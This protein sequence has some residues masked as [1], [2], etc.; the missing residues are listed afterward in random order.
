MES[1]YRV[2]STFKGSTHYWGSDG[3][4]ALRP[5]NALLMTRDKA[6][7]IVERE[8]ANYECVGRQ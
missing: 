8:N 2:Y 1:L 3:C 6:L 4:W 7:L 5:R